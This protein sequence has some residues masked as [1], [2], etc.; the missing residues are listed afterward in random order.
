M[1][2]GVCAPLLIMKKYRIVEMNQDGTWKPLKGLVFKKYLQA[3]TGC[4]ALSRVHTGT[5]YK[6]EEIYV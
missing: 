3:E 4:K 6:V 2:R 5:R 1:G